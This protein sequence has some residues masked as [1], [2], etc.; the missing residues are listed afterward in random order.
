VDLL[1]DCIFLRIVR[2]SWLGFDAIIVAHLFELTFESA[3]IV[4]GN[5][6]RTRVSCQPGVMKLFLDGSSHFISGFD[7]LKPSSGWGWIYHSMR[8]FIATGLLQI[9]HWLVLAAG[10]E[11]AVVQKRCFPVTTYS[12]LWLL[13]TPVI[14]TYINHIIQFS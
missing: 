5:K 10:I 8:I 7:N 4:K 11:P 3:S 9:G 14:Q 6:L 1:N 2:W 13:V 12:N